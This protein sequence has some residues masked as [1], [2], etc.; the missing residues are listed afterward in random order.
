[1]SSPNSDPAFNPELGASSSFNTQSQMGLPEILQMCCVSRRS[2]QITFRSGE[3]YGFIYIQHGR[4]LHALCGTTEGEEAI[5]HMLTWPGGGFSLDEGI[6]P[7][8]KTVTLTWEQLLF[9]GARRADE[10]LT[11]PRMMPDVPVKTEANPSAVHRTQEN[12]PR[13]IISGPEVESATFELEQEYTHAGRSSDNE[14]HLPF[15]SVSTR[16]CIF[17]LSGADVVV[18]DLN[19]SNGTFVNGAAID[20]TILRPGDQIQ[21]GT[22][23]M[24]FE[25]GIKRPKL[26]APSPSAATPATKDGFGMLPVKASRGSELL[27]AT[28]KISLPPRPSSQAD[29]SAYV[30]GVSAISYEALPKPEVE[31]KKTP[32]IMI[33]VFLVLVIIGVFCY[34]HFVLHK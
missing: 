3:S 20:E 32:W 19:S 12:Q 10:G 11:V 25:P 6:L 33:I 9:E 34:W 4:V 2:G 27:N 28:V 16:H 8:K 5:Y 24:K 14:I 7:H 23:Q 13:L 1:M 18:R 31:K 22:I 30:K 26:V 15:S 17:I 29:D 21:L